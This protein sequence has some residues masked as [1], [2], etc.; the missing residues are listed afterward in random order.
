MI[1][2]DLHR[3]PVVV[4]NLCRWH[5][6]KYNECY[7]Q[8]ACKTTT[9]VTVL[10]KLLYEMKRKGIELCNNPSTLCRDIQLRSS[11]WPN[12]RL[13]A[14]V[15]SI[16]GQW[17]VGGRQDRRRFRGASICS[18]ETWHLDQDVLMYERK[19]SAPAGANCPGSRR[20]G[21]TKE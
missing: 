15:E 2:Q 7:E 18:N 3:M 5:D 11:I 4:K 1:S 10:T 16:Q 8:L 9:L 13:L 21:R 12:K 19:F 20:S 14:Q 6:M 17:L